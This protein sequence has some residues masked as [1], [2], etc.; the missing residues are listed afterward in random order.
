MDVAATQGEETVGD[1]LR[2]WRRRRRVSQLD[3]AIEAGVSARHVSFLETGRARPSREMVMRLSDHLG[4]P[5]RHRNRLLVA[6]GHAPVYRE[7]PIAAPEMGAVRGALDKILA[8]HEPYPALVVDRAWDLVAANRGAGL[9]LD[10]LP[11]DLLKEPVNVLRLTLHPDGL[12]R[13]LANLSEV[14][15][16]LLGHLRAQ[17]ESSGEP[18]LADLHDEL[19]AYR[20]PGAEPGPARPYATGDVLLPLRLRRGGA[21]LS[22]FTTIAVFGTPLDVTVSELAIELF[23][24]NDEATAA[25]LRG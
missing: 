24:P 5:L 9:F 2:E 8:G 17:A 19:A 14:R 10:G 20:Y 4:V 1:L 6:A 25:L 3:L 11:A 12:A 21:V 23:W 18:R 16:H 13:D 22:M 7:R 15:S